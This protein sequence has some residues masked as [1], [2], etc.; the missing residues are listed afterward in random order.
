MTWRILVVDDE[1]DIAE[2]VR[3][4]LAS[5]EVGEHPAYR[6]ESATSFV[7]ALD[8]LALSHFDLL[9]LDVR[10]QQKAA[11]S[12][13]AA[14]ADTGI[15]TFTEV[16]ERRFIPIVFHTALPELVLDLTNPPFVSVVSKLDDD[17]IQK[18]RAAVETALESTLPTLHRALVR[19]VERVTRDFMIDFVELNWDQ[20]RSPGR[21]G[22][23]AHL[24]L[25]RLAL[26]L[27]TG[28][29]VLAGELGNT[30][31]ATLTPDTV[32]PMRFY[33]TPPI[34]DHVTGDLLH[35]PRILP[36]PVSAEGGSDS[37]KAAWYVTLTPACDL[38]AGRVKADYVVVAECIALAEFPEFAAWQAEAAAS[39]SAKKKLEAL[40]RNNPTGRQAD[41]YYYLP[42]AWGVPDLVVDVQRIAHLPY[43][44]LPDYT[45]SATLDSPYAEALS[46]QFGRY[47]GRV[48]TP[49]LDHDLAI[50]RLSPSPANPPEESTP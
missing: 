50:A 17:A 23:V 34:G 46:N 38:V 31:D 37:G 36:V 15:A 28:A 44:R 19:H 7:D 24:L 29:Q 9:V 40:M 48:G 22:D 32:H 2:Q 42:A 47:M 4:L 35:G 41:R 11:Q 12:I 14:D 49:N 26:S 27:A 1:P 16:R 13:E 43:E 39:S 10:D 18:L 20:L 3:E 25:R 21:R 6:V 45:R 8:R 33:V 5:V 30:D